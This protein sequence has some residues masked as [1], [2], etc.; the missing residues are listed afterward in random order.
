[1]LLLFAMKS[2]QLVCYNVDEFED[3]VKTLKAVDD[4]TSD[5]DIIDYFESNKY[6]L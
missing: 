1:M 3:F 2:L 6:L 4:A 5:E